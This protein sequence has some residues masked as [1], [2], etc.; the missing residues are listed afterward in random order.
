[1]TLTAGG[2]SADYSVGSP[3]TALTANIMPKA[4]NY[5]GVGAT[6]KVYDGTTTA[7]ALGGGGG[8]GGRSAR[9]FNVRRPALHG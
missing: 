5:T 6:N 1:M 7:S 8:A 4:L 9:E 2:Q 3:N